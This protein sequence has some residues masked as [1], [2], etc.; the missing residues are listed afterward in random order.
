M[1]K[2]T[3]RK[4]AAELQKKLAAINVLL[5]E[6]VMEKEAASDW[7]AALGKARAEL[8]KGG[9]EKPSLKEVSDLAKEK[10]FTPK[11]DS[12]E[13]S[14]EYDVEANENTIVSQIDEIAGMLEQQGDSE[15][16]KVAYQLDVVSDVLEGKKTAAALESEPDE[17]YM[18]KYFKAGLREGEADEKSY[19]KE[20]NT[21]LSEETSRVPGNVSV[22][23]KNASELPYRKIED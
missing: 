17:A 6:D 20:F 9:K 1:D 16:M 8:K 19:M 22:E 5:G 7:I 10:Y 3:L 12:K 18:K 13:A 21:D 2:D 4:E 14:E 23:H 11:N 15:L